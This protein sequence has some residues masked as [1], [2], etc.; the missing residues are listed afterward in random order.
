[1][2]TA[3]ITSA[4]LAHGDVWQVQGRL[5]EPHGGGVREMPGIR[6]MASG[7]PYAQWNNGDVDN[8]AR[9]DIGAVR[10]W[11][12][13]RCVR[14]GVRV[15]AGMP[16]PYG[17][18]LFRKRLMRRA[19]APLVSLPLDRELGLRRASSDDLSAVVDV[20]SSAFG[21]PPEMLRPWI[22]P[23]L[24]VGD[25]TV[26]LAELSGDPVGTAYTILSHGRAGPCVYLGGVAVRP[27][28][29]RRGVATA[30]SAWLLQRGFAA[31]ALLAHL[32]PDNDE[33]ARVYGRLGFVE[34]DGLDVYVN[35]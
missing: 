11:Y 10:A 8:P 15:P 17:R 20:D 9:V 34:Q 19:A 12:A 27:D 28:A 18:Y 30:L 29:R 23:H 4:Q 22:E 2:G 26:G 33:A 1:M 3:V 32:D 35:L 7:L 21:D 16:W 5:R 31:G 13:Q 24:N 6:L 25:V 14:W